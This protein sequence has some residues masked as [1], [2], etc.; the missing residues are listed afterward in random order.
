MKRS[1]SKIREIL[2]NCEAAEATWFDLRFDWASSEPELEITSPWSELERYQ[3]QLMKDAGLIEVRRKYDAYNEGYV[4]AQEF[5]L[6][7]S[8]HDYL[9]AIKNEGVWQQTKAVV[10]AEGGSLALEIVKSLALGFAK[11]QVEDRTGI[12]L[13]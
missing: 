5:R 1:L 4:F 7:N 10:A 12:K 2:S 3:I 11:K 9:D 8:G 6:T 13:L